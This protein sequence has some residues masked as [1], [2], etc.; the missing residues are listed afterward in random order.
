MRR[1]EIRGP[2]LF[3]SSVDGRDGA[4]E[5]ILAALAAGPH[6]R[7]G[8][9]SSRRYWLLAGVATVLAIAVLAQP[10]RQDVDG[11]ALAA[12]PVPPA[13]R[14]PASMASVAA[15]LPPEPAHAADAAPARII[16]LA[17]EAGPPA[18]KAR[19]DRGAASPPAEAAP[20]P[21]AGASAAQQHAPLRARPR[22]SPLRIAPAAP[23]RPP[24]GRNRTAP[25]VEDRDVRVLAALM[26][27]GQSSD[28]AEPPGERALRECGVLAPSD[29]EACVASL[30]ARGRAPQASCEGFARGPLRA[31]STPP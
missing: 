16:D 15:P 28:H 13:P 31:R 9:R 23:G 17:K 1:G 7:H 19:P 5:G 4:G 2:S 25:E 10:A 27:G 20:P 21:Q 18:L 3:S 22:A 26:R 30:C 11:G 24:A 29:R 14:A 8:P 12:R 6:H